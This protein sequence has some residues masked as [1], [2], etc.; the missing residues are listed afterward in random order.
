M[1]RA[2][3]YE[4]LFNQPL[5]EATGSL[6]VRARQRGQRGQLWSRLTGR[7]RGLLALEEIRSVCSDQAR[8]E[9]GI[10]TVPID[11]IRGSE[12]RAAD[13][14]CDFN[15]LQAHTS[16]R[17]LSIAQARRQG[18]A[19]P[20]V[21]LIRVGDCYFVRDGHH[22]I[23]VARALGDVAVEAR[24][25]VVKVEGPL[26]WEPPAP[27]GSRGFEG[28]VKKLRSQGARLQERALLGCKRVL[29]VA[30]TGWKRPAM[31]QPGADV[32]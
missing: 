32:L 6:Y 22:R 8:A 20:P 31:S 9:G 13:F 18:R 4:P 17:W 21:A 26:P 29:G 15:P 28:F 23:S 25:V 24:V 19:L 30:G 7:S 2:L 1:H 5:G 10:R 3:S 12:N 11:Q 16:A 14:D 27:A